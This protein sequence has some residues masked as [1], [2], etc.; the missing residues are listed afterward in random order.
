M[1]RREGA[2]AALTVAAAAESSVPATAASKSSG[3]GGVRETERKSGRGVR[4]KG[5]EFGR[6]EGDR[7]EIGERSEGERRRVRAGSRATASDGL[8]EEADFASEKDE[9]MCKK[10]DCAR[11]TAQDFLEETTHRAWKGGEE[12][13]AK[14]IGSE[15]NDRDVKGIPD[16]APQG[17]YNTKTPDNTYTKEIMIA[18]E[19][20]DEARTQVRSDNEETEGEKISS[21]KG[22]S[23]PTKVENEYI[24][25]TVGDASDTGEPTGKPADVDD[26]VDDVQEETIGSTCDEQHQ[27]N[28]ESNEKN[29]DGEQREDKHQTLQQ[30]ELVSEVENQETTST[31]GAKKMEISKEGENL[32]NMISE[33]VNLEETKIEND[34][35]DEKIKES[36]EDNPRDH[37]LLSQTRHD[38]ADE[39]HTKADQSLEGKDGNIVS[40]E[41]ESIKSKG[42]DEVHPSESEAH[43]RLVDKDNNIVSLEKES[44]ESKGPDEVQPGESEA[45]KVA[46]IVSTTDEAETTSVD[47]G[48]SVDVDKD[49][50]EYQE[51]KNV[52]ESV[53][54]EYNKGGANETQ[55]AKSHQIPE[56][57]DLSPEKASET[58]ESTTMPEQS[59]IPEEENTI[60]ESKT[61]SSFPKDAIENA[62]KSDPEEKDEEMLKNDE[63]SHIFPES[64]P[65]ADHNIAEG[66]CHQDEGN[67]IYEDAAPETAFGNQSCEANEE[68]R[69]T[70]KKD[71]PMKYID[72]VNSQEETI[73]KEDSDNVEESEKCAGE[74]GTALTLE[75]ASAAKDDEQREEKFQNPHDIES[76]MDVK[77][78]KTTSE[79]ESSKTTA[80]DGLSEEAD[81]ASEKDE[82]MCKKGDCARETV[83][84]FSEETTHRAGKGGEETDTKN[85]G[86]EDND[87][88]VK[89]I[90]DVAPQGDYNTKTPNN[91]Y[92][93]EIMIAVE[94]EDEAR[95]QVS[96][97]NEKTEGEKISSVKGEPTGKP[98]NVDDVVDDVQ[99]ETIG[100]ICEEQH[101]EN[102]ESN[103]KNEEADED[104]AEAVQ[105]LE[106]K[107]GNIASLEKESIKSKGPDEVHPSESEAHQSL[108]DKDNN[109]VSFEKESIESKGPDEIQL[110]E[111]EGTKVAEIVSTTDEAETTSVDGGESVDVD[112]D[113][114]EYQEHKNV[115]ESVMEEYNQGEANETQM[116]KSH[117][118]PEMDDLS[119]EKAS[120][121][122]ESVMKDMHDKTKTKHEEEPDFA[123]NKPINQTTMPE[124]SRIPEEENTIM[125]SK[126]ES[127]FPK[128]AI[129]N[130]LKSDPEEKDEEMQ[131][132]KESSHIFLESSPDTDHNIAEGLC[133]L[134]EGN[135]T[136]E[137]AAPETAS[138]NQS[139]EANEEQSEIEKQDM[140]MKY[141]DTV[142]SQEETIHKEDSDNVEES[143]KC[144]GKDGTALT[145]ERASAAE[146]DEKREEKFQNPHDIESETDIKKEKTTSEAEST[147]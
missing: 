90:P 132:N 24:S 17:D 119:P 5:E 127:S 67:K 44:I 125:E 47:G 73:H 105:S 98:A 128:D 62:L 139:C 19:Q 135:K 133:H 116:A 110:S 45:T 7:E 113:K 35:D 117:K 37:A 20:E 129:E 85:I 23:E 1:L 49:K 12:T 146:D 51:H 123:S 134:D 65:D 131:K 69:E 14:N 122:N 2:V 126:T 87:R 130:A 143:E 41:K 59:R 103:E 26:V 46:E 70:E 53:M 107:D 141:I 108:E 64:S 31:T 3:S 78:E 115:R 15:D 81:F 104:H 43:Q 63:S 83:Q 61:E 136:C 124:Q 76:E 84:D 121:T 60:M 109:I 138:G 72:T 39:D 9:N 102:V 71:M 42:P 28:I 30:E 11:E 111:L 27:E 79:A 77:K 4:E 68:Q 97:D 18:I 91:T 80:S 101:Q 58:N 54:E 120:E 66:L 88:D 10:D 29:E 96:S 147:R 100:S 48:E 36:V 114:A 106:G 8:S 56:M 112:K 89:G 137:D 142:N 25:N 94:Q 50:A 93:K 34:T 140:P 6:S 144:E 52:I 21:V 22:D 75:R 38:V 55:M 57:D 74:D 40:L 82:N 86:G 118:I 145:L 95:T 16:V 33:S 32:I 99:E 92:T 13:D